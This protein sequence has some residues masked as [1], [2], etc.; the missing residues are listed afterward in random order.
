MIFL[1]HKTRESCSKIT[2]NKPGLKLYYAFEKMPVS[3]FDV[4]EGW[5]SMHFIPFKNIFLKIEI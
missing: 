2:L 4:S 3:L 1:F 5:L